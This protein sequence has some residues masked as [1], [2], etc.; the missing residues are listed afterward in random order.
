[1]GRQRTGVLNFHAETLL[2]LLSPFLTWA[3][4]LWDE[5][6][7]HR[8]WQGPGD[9]QHSSNGLWCC[10]LWSQR[11]ASWKLS[12][13]GF[14]QRLLRLGVLERGWE[15]GRFNAKSRSIVNATHCDGWYLQWVKTINRK[16]L[17]CRVKNSTKNFTPGKWSSANLNNVN[18][19][20]IESFTWNLYP[21]TTSWENSFSQ[22]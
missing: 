11:L 17:L 14:F 13:M 3:S 19:L 16:N 20:R 2:K 1:M 8:W 15:W 22:Y 5:D 9:W 10:W 12:Q 21:K 18:W 4:F 7:S 6:R